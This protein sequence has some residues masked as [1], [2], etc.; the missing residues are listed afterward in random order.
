MAS[1]GNVVSQL[2]TP[3]SEAVASKICFK[4]GSEQIYVGRLI[5]AMRNPH[6]TPLDIHQDHKKYIVLIN[7]QLEGMQHNCQTNLA[8][9]TMEVPHTGK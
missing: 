4:C 8:L 1:D 2:V 9:T 5:I 6:D 3:C 7:G